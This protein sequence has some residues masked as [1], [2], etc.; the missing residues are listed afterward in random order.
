MR[1]GVFL[2]EKY[3][4]IPKI[5]MWWSGVLTVTVPLTNCYKNKKGIFHEVVQIQS[6][7]SDA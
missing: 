5:R 6:Q 1:E 3:L 4:R 7:N 2:V